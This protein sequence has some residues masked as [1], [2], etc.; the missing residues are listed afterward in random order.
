MS[1]MTLERLPPEI[2]DA[3]N[4][5]SAPVATVSPPP[6]VSVAGIEQRACTQPKEG[7]ARSNT[8][9]PVAEMLRVAGD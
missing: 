4:L 5:P 1:R 2:A 6:A 9:S 8:G 7:V 3:H